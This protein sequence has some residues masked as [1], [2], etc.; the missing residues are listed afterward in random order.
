MMVGLMSNSY[1]ILCQLS[2]QSYKG[3]T[4]RE[5]V[6]KRRSAVDMDGVT[7]ME[8]GTFYQIVLHCLSS[9]S[10]AREKQRKQ[11]TLPFRA[12]SWDSEV[13]AALFVHRVE[14]LPMGLYFLLRNEDHF[15]DLKRATRSE[16]KWEKPEGCPD[17]LPLYELARGSYR[18]LAKKLSCHQF[19][20]SCRDEISGCSEKAYDSLSINDARKILMFSSDHELFEYIK[21]EH[22]VWEIKNGFVIFHRAKESAPCKEIPSLQLINQT[23]SYARELERIV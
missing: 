12:L 19:I 8:R 23:L 1:T 7:V 2:E 6:R 22:P 17:D 21:E 14:G 20:V 4:L 11:M 15:H 5:V 18:Q 3:F 16:F 9:G 13:H 10:R